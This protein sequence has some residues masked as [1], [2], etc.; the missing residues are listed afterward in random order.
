MDASEQNAK[1][2]EH[3]GRYEIMRVVFERFLADG[4]IDYAEKELYAKLRD[5]FELSDARSSQV[6]KEVVESIK[7]TESVRE[8]AELRLSEDKRGYRRKLYSDILFSLYVSGSVTPEENELISRICAVIGVE[9][10]LEQECHEEVERKLFD[11][12][13]RFAGEK[14]YGEAFDVMKKVRP[15]DPRAELYFGT[16]Y[17]IISALRDGMRLQ[18]GAAASEFEKNFSSFSA[19][20]RCSFWYGLFR[21]RLLPASDFAA[22]E[23]ALLK[24]VEAAPGEKEKF[25][26]L[27]DLAMLNHVGSKFE[28]AIGLYSEAG[29]IDPA[30]PDVHVN[31]ASCLI[32]LGK[33]G[34]AEAVCREAAV[35]FPS[36]PMLLNNMGIALSKANKNDES[37]KCFEKA[38]AVSPG[39]SDARLNLIGLFI[40]MNDAG[41][42]LEHIAEFEKLFP[43]DRSVSGLKARAARLRTR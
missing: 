27:F 8:S 22:K 6:L 42:A 4:R 32:S 33:Y 13:V 39:F 26:A 17:R 30:D 25:A 1:K 40:S 21:S 28:E 20:N 10:D 43:G 16:A 38:L 11:L 5:A 15:S 31:K 12:A 14:K 34:E 37:I 29:L 2:E 35:K 3:L 41:K 9:E 24:A 36:N 19:S 18:A 7:K 23:S